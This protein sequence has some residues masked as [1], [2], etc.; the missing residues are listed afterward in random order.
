MATSI[1][2]QVSTYFKLEKQVACA[3]FNF[4]GPCFGPQ[5]FQNLLNNNIIG[6]SYYESFKKYYLVEHLNPKPQIALVKF[7]FMVSM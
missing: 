3:P 6:T 2:I 5:I 7:F 4:K 1:I